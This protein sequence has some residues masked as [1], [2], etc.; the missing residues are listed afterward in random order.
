M[1]TLSVSFK[2]TDHELGLLDV[3][4]LAITVHMLLPLNTLLN[5]ENWIVK[6]LIFVS[7]YKSIW[8]P[9]QFILLLCCLVQ[10]DQKSPGII[11][12][13]VKDVFSIIQEVDDFCSQ[14]YLCPSRSSPKSIVNVPQTP[15]RE[16]LLRV[17]Y[18]EIYNEVSN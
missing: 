2:K 8:M 1:N 6:F 13:A 4:S 16:F 9:L 14:K 15:G 10:G 12:L 3:A 11:P 7:H 5:W 17:S 18:L